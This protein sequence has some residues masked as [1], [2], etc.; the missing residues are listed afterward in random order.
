M[1][2][3][4]VHFLVIVALLSLASSLVSAYDPSPLQDICVAIDDPKSAVFVNGKFCKDLEQSKAEDFFFSGLQNPGNTNNPVGS[5]VTTVNVDQIPGLNTLGISLVRIDFA[6]DGENPPHTH[7]RGTEILVVLEGTLYV[8]FVTSNPENRLFSK[9]LNKGDVFV[10][11]IGLIHFQFN[12]GHTNAVA[13]SGLSS[14]NAG[15][16]TIANAVFGSNPPINPDVL[17][18]AFQLDK[19]IIEYL[20]KTF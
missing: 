19:K 3:K 20:Q 15:V 4:G 12:V 7:P 1:S 11:P 13:F 9:I 5:N 10:F 14:Q 16:I 8:G 2:T 6:P 18:K 17:T